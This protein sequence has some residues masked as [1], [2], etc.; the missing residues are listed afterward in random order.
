MPNNRRM[1]NVN[2]TGK[3]ALAAFRRIGLALSENPRSEHSHSEHS[4]SASMHMPTKI[5]RSSYAPHHVVSD[6]KGG[7]R[8]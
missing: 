8:L 2:T 7:T 1:L 6:L 5:G 3:P 4:R